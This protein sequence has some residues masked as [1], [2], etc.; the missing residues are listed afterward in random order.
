MTQDC[1]GSSHCE[2]K[3]QFPKLLTNRPGLPH[4]DFRIGAYPD[5][6]EAIMRRLN[7]DPVLS[8][9]TYRGSDDPGIALLEGAAVLGDILTFYQELYANEAYLGTA[10]WRESV[11]DLVR[12]TGYL[13]SPGVGGKASF[14]T[15]SPELYS[16]RKLSVVINRSTSPRGFVT[17][18]LPEMRLTFFLAILIIKCER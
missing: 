10:L 4:I 3:L 16:C 2:G 5:F 18:Q 12:L 6:L 17:P 11:A 8:S 14:A 7:T 13:L 15:A 9:W 1:S